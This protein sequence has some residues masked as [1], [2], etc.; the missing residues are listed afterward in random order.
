MNDHRLILRTI[1][2]D[3]EVDDLLRDR[4][5]ERQ[6]PKAG[7]LRKYLQAGMKAVKSGWM[8]LDAAPLPLNKVLVL[9]TAHMDTK[10][11]SLLRVEAFDKSVSKNDLFRRYVLL[12]IHAEAESKKPLKSAPKKVLGTTAGAHVP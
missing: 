12:G 11:D 6:V 2:L 7:L 10:V 3:P 8:S 4:A 9:R 1:Y 5:E